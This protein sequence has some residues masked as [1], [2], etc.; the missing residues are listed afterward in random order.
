MIAQAPE[1]ASGVYESQRQRVCQHPNPNF[2]RDRCPH[3]A[4]H[5]QHLLM[6]RRPSALGRHR[7]RRSHSAG[8]RRLRSVACGGFGRGTWTFQNIR[9]VKG[10]FSFL[11]HVHQLTVDRAFKDPVT[12]PRVH[13]ICPMPE[14]A[15]AA[16]DSSW[17]LSPSPAPIPAS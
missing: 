10:T 2:Y 16:S 9:A 8:P 13:S 17:L 5:M 15:P 14:H 12:N 11:R 1:P 6:P 7:W 4:Q 3:L